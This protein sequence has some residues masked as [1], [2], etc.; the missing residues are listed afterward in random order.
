M[1]KFKFFD[2]AELVFGAGSLND[3]HTLE[4][5]GKKALLVISNGRSARANGYLDRTVAELDAAGVEHVIFDKVAA[6]PL[7]SVVEEGARLGREEKVDFVVALGG[8]SVM[9]A[10]KIMAM[11]IPQPSD[12]LWDYAFCPAGKKQLPPEP[13]LPWIAI[14]TSAGTGSEVDAIGVITNPDTNEKVGL[15]NFKGM[16]ARYAIVDPELMKS[17]PP[18]FTAF[19]GFDALFHSLEGYISN[20]HN[21]MGDMIQRTAI[22]NIGK[23]LPRAVKDGSDMEAREHVAFANTLSGYSMVVASNVSEHSIEHAMSAYHGDLPHGAGLIMISKEYFTFWINKHV[24][25]DRFVDMARF[26]GRADAEKPEDFIDA[27][28]DLQKACGVDDLKMSDYGLKKE[29][30]MKIA[31]KAKESMARL[32]AADPADTT[33]EEIAGIYERSYR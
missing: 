10:A 5:P 23:Y 15:G 14:T 1:K 11:F 26:L 20:K 7:K 22:E 33:N 27:L 28:M 18:K 16:M 32:F 6:N 17:V 24:C 12:D 8:G 4:M 31:V 9:D 29:E 3:L 21:L 30:A 13:V 19:Q 2:T 25:D